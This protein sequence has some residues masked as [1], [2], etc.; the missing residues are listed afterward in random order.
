M[1]IML[2]DDEE[3]SRKAIFNFLK[4]QLDL[5]IQEF[6]NALEA[7]EA[8][9]K[10]H[11][12]I[13]ISDIKMPGINGIEFLQEIKKR[14]E[15]KFTDIILITGFGDLESAVEALRS[16]AYDYLQKPINIEE[17]YS[18]IQKSEEHLSLLIENREYKEEFDKLVKKEKQVLNEK[19]ISIQETFIN[20][21]GYG[22]IGVFSEH[23]KKIMD[24]CIKLHIDRNIPV[25]IEGDTGTGKEIVARM[26]HQGGIET[27]KSPFIPLNCAAIPYNLFENELF[28]HEEG[29][30]TDSKKSGSI[31]KLELANNGTLFLD[32]IGEMPL[33]MQS[34]LLR[35]IEEKEFFK[36]GGVKKIKVNVRVICASNKNI[37]E[38]VDEGKFR[39]DLFYRLNTAYIKLKPLYKRKEEIIPLANIFLRRLTN[40]KRKLFKGITESASKILTSY[41]WPG[42]VR[43]LLNTI[44][45][46][47]LLH[48]EE[49]IRSEH[50][51]FIEFSPNTD[52]NEYNSVNIQMSEII[53]PDEGIDLKK[54]EKDLVL[55]VLKKFNG[56]K[57]KTAE[58]LNLTRSALRSKLR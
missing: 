28:G 34:K 55:K 48:N 6:D 8:F 42:N 4:G 46:V 7:L 19:C 25:L 53:L 26:V 13:V 31:G 51:N 32:E 5:D 20:I 23:L 30:F 29:S 9:K 16:G 43:E 10:S 1:K 15:G 37:K 41:N 44:E 58:Y 57:T 50:L 2:V 35:V 49:F 54:F 18:I 11:F 24:Q 39:N 56:N 47:V 36:L 3:V 14:P 27:I 40:K 45:R 33:G 38:L 12:Q 17:L 21:A 22:E 52:N